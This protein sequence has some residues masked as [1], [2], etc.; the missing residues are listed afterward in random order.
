MQVIS[1]F[2]IY[3]QIL[4]FCKLDGKTN[5][6]IRRK[7]DAPDTIM[8]E[9]TRKQF[10]WYGHV[11]RMDPTRLPKIVINWKP[12]GR[13]NGAVPKEPGQM[14]YTST[15]TAIS[16]RGQEWANGTTEGNGIGTSVG[17]VRRFKTARIYTLHFLDFMTQ[18]M[19]NYHISEICLQFV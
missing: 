7:M 18:K 15:Y 17:V 19:K 13:K 9:V 6:Y 11:E 4:I 5:E 1:F 3:Y 10:I 8:D 12:E 2:Q 16:V 14:G